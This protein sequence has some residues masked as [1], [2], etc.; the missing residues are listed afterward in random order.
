[1]GAVAN[2]GCWRQVETL[3]LCEGP[4][5]VDVRLDHSAAMVGFRPVYGGT[6]IDVF[7][8]NRPG[9]LAAGDILATGRFPLVPYSGRIE[10][11]CL[12]FQDCT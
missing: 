11:A 6:V 8:P 7:E 2:R 3:T 9:A 1:M 5:E 12:A 10:G 4:K